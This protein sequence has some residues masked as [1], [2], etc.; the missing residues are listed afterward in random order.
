LCVLALQS[1]KW[2][3]GYVNVESLDAIETLS[4][5]VTDGVC[6]RMLVSREEKGLNLVLSVL[7][8]IRADEYP[9]VLCNMNLQVCHRFASSS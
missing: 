3:K 2:A 5:V 4:A 6:L 7:S 8:K 1:S 9:I